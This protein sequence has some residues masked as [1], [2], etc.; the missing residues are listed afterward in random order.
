MTNSDISDVTPPKRWRRVVRSIS[1][2]ILWPLLLPWRFV[3]WL[4]RQ[5][6]QYAGE[7]WAGRRAWLK[8]QGRRWNAQLR[9]WRARLRL[10]LRWR[11][12]PSGAYVAS[13]TVEPT[14]AQRR[15]PLLT[16]TALVSVL[17]LAGAGWIVIDRNNR[18]AAE[19]AALAA[20]PAATLTPSPVPTIT[21]TPT[22]TPTP[23]PTFTP[24]P[25]TVFLTPWPTPDPL[26][27]G[28]SI[29]FAMNQAGNHDIYALSIGQDEP[30]RLTDHPAVERDPAWR[31]DGREIAF[32]SRRSGS[33]DLYVLDMP[34]GEIQQLTDS[35]EFEGAP[36]WSPDG[37]WLVYEGYRGGNLDIY[38]VR[39]D[40]SEAPIRL[41][42]HPAADFSPVW[43]PDGRQIA[44]TSWRA[45]N[46]DIFVLSLDNLRDELA[47]NLT[48][49]G[50]RHEDHAAYHPNGLFL[51]YTESGRGLDLI[52]A[53]PL[54]GYR[55]DGDPITIG[56]GRDPAW[57][58]NGDNLTYGHTLADANYLIASS[59]DAWAIA[60]QTYSGFGEITNPSWSGVTLAPRP[61]GFLAD[62]ARSEIAP[63]FTETISNT[64]Q[65]DPPFLLMSVD[66][67][68]SLPYFSDRVEQ[69]FMA[70]RGRLIREAGWDPLGNLAQAFEPI[71]AQ[72]EPNE[73]IR[74]WHKAGRAFD[75]P[76]EEIL[77]FN[78]N[79]EVVRELVNGET[80]WRVYYRAA[81][82]DGSMGEPLRQLPWDFR[83]RFGD[84]PQYYDQGGR[85]KESIPEGYYVDFT[86][87][88]ADYG[89]HRVPAGDNWR[90]YFPA[91]R[92]WQYEKRDDLTW[93]AAMREIYAEAEVVDRFGE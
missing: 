73:S 27:G 92:F 61:V 57:S 51:A 9:V 1:H 11:K 79:I 50:D 13:T 28:G 70:L 34:T 6:R 82:Q 86:A 21:L 31:P 89:W 68:T 81:V 77:T 62:V 45:G 19:T 47:V 56:Q 41:T 42:E 44:F 4:G 60:P 18:L 75:L 64:G 93:V 46:Q 3:R 37:Q 16:A 91:V 12:P 52:I 39:R 78:P 23:L 80:Y 33:W 54:V 83:A 26:I 74:S 71:D 55:P 30:V 66:V 53:Q 72:P 87:V 14:F 32:V 40:G 69:S 88:A 10:W 63:L 84:D 59:I 58:P 5:A 22:L 24:T 8:W 90:T 76:Y 43:S 29:V 65:T 17:I 38:I 35:P 7:Q 67:E 2:I 49:T 85:L 25:A 15:L 48:G 20:L 36:R